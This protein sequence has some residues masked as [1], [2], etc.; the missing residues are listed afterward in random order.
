MSGFV[1]VIEDIAGHCRI[2]KTTVIKYGL[3]SPELFSRMR[4]VLSYSPFKSELAF[5]VYHE[6]Y[7][8]LEDALMWKFSKLRM[9]ADWFRVSSE[10]IYQSLPLVFD[11]MKTKALNSDRWHSELPKHEVGEL[12]MSMGLPEEQI[13]RGSSY[14]VNFVIFQTILNEANSNS[15]HEKA[16]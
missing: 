10:E 1:Y 8:E 6:N 15:S 3:S 7:D 12:A 5:T 16:A 2:G 4:H 9:N 11:V 13:K 14:C